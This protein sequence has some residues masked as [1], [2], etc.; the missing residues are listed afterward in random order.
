MSR[1][2]SLDEYKQDYESLQILS[3][4]LPRIKRAAE[5]VSAGK[6]YY[7]PVEAALGIPWY[8]VGIVHLLEGNCS[9][10][11]GLHS[12]ESWRRVTKLEEKGRGPFASW[13]AAAIDALR[14][15]RKTRPDM[16][17]GVA[18]WSPIE[19]LR[20]LERYNGGGYLKRG[21][22][23]PYL[24][25]GSNHGVG[26]GK[27]V[28]DGVYDPNAVSEQV[29]A[30]CVMWALLS[31]EKITPPVSD[32]R[33]QI[34]SVADRLDEMATKKAMDVEALKAEAKRLRLLAG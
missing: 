24:W 30:A 21:V 27:Y 10:E 26:V 19:S 5:K 20:F 12:G 13:E 7:L 29:G 15:V 34:V 17:D 23:S 2:G 18:G 31:S 28:R 1:N 9:W 16:W 32:L 14:E 8:V 6:K 11:K 22:N 33:S 25:S 3:S 4:W